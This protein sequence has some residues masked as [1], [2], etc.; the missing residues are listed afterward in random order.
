M[1]WRPL[2]RPAVRDDGSAALELVIL[3]P[4]LLTLLA[5]AIIGMRIEVA[6]ATIEGAAHD[7]ARAA[8]LT[9]NAGDAAA[10]AITT[11]RAGLR[12][13]GLSCTPDVVVDT[14]GFAAPAGQV[15]TVR[16]TIGCTVSFA[17]VTGPGL[18]GSR[19]ITSSFTSVIDV[20]RGRTVG[21]GSPVAPPAV[22]H[23]GG[24]V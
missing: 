10:A 16:V 21:L 22:N 3:A 15:G 9:R 13:Q 17:D 6:G 20:Y 7:A 19:R 1:T 12:Q 24:A 8:S 23:R 2:R 18:P 11:A 5:L 4:P 14:S